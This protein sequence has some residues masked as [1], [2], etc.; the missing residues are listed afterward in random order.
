MNFPPGPAA[1]DGDGPGAV[2]AR[3]TGR[4]VTGVRTLSGSLA[5]AVLDDGRVVVVKSAD[6]GGGRARRGGGAA[7]AGRGRDGAGAGGAR[8]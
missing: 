5:E 7:L 4:A 6:G 2:A 8:S 3:F 1:P